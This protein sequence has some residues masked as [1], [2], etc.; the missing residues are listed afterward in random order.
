MRVEKRIS[1]LVL[2]FQCIFGSCVGIGDK[3]AVTKCEALM[4]YFLPG[5]LVGFIE[6]HNSRRIN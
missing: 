4:A 3:F 2:F 5:F 6:I 1:G